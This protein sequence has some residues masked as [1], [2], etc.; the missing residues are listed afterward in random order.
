MGKDKLRKWEENKT[1]PHVFEPPLLP[2]IREKKDF[3]LKGKWKL[4]V[5]GN[6]RP[7]V[8]ELGCGKGEYTV[9]MARRYPEKNFIGI[10]VKG[11]RFHKGARDS[12]QL[13]LSNVAFLRMRIEFIESFFAKGEVDEIWITFCDPF[14]LDYRGHRRMTS[15]WYLKKYRQIT[16]PPFRIHLKHDNAD[17]HKRA[18]RE[19]TEAGLE[20][21]IASDDIYGAFQHEVEEE[22][23]NLLLIRTYYESMWLEKGRKITYIRALQPKL[24][25]DP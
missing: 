5:F 16:K 25:P 9:E 18:L 8:I 15:L 1:F 14:P 21:E 7:L 17:L 11:H 2:V 6:D 23:R 20:V 19:W 24:E 22:L 13:G 4:E 10:D 3:D 12:M